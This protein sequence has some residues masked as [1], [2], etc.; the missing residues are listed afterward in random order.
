MSFSTLKKMGANKWRNKQ[1]KVVLWRDMDLG[2]LNNL[3]RFLSRAINKYED[4]AAAAAGYSGN[5]DI[6]QYEADC[7]MSRA[8][9][10][11]YKLADYQTSLQHYITLREDSGYIVTGP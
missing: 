3:V 1:D 11:A 9:N 8:F 4:E 2:Y 6:A 5:G 7:A 10:R